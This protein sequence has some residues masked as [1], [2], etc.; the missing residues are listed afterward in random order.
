M[1]IK[2]QIG[3]ESDEIIWRNS[4][5]LFIDSNKTLHIIDLKLGGARGALRTL[6]VEK[7]PRL[8]LPIYGVP[9]NVS[10]GELEFSRFLEQLMK[11]KDKLRES[12]EIFPENKGML[13][14]LC[15]ATDFLV[16]R[17]DQVREVSLELIYPLAEPLNLR[18]IVQNRES[19]KLFLEEI[20][21]LYRSLRVKGSPYEEIDSDSAYRQKRV[22]E[23][24]QKALL[25]LR[26]KMQERQEQPIRLSTGDIAEARQDVEQRLKAFFSNP[27][28]CKGIALLHSAGSGKTSTTRNQILATPGKHIV[29]YMATRISLLDREYQ[30][31]NQIASQEERKITLVYKRE[32]TAQLK[33]A[34]HKGDSWE[35]KT[36]YAKGK[37][38]TAVEEIIRLLHQPSPPELLWA[39]VTLQAIVKT[40]RDHRTSKHLEDL[41]RPITK[42][43]HIHIILDEFLGHKNG[44]FAILELLQF[45]K[46]AR[47]HKRKINLYLFDA[48]AYSPNL[49]EKLI[50]E[51]KEFQVIPES[52]VLVPYDEE[53]KIAV[54]E[55]PLEIYAKHG[56]PS[57]QLIIQK[58]FVEVESE[59][60]IAEQV[61]SYI[62]A[63][64]PREESTAFLFL[65]NKDLIVETSNYLRGIGFSTLIATATSKKTQKEI[66][67]GGEDVILGTSSVSRGLD[68][69]RPHK[70]VNNIYIVVQN[71]GI[72]NNLVEILQ[73]VSRS[74]GDKTTESKPKTLHLLYLINRQYD[75]YRVETLTQML[76]HGDRNLVPLMYEKET[77]RGFVDLDEV[78][79]KILKQFLDRPSSQVLVLSR[80]NILVASRQM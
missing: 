74:R 35:L 63:T 31:L 49:L 16:E 58:R 47:D 69:S 4:D 53:R 44:L 79:T 67:E 60:K 11:I 39:F 27:A 76:E 19:L 66:N 78:I 55:I 8:P 36:N 9:V 28:P 32:N 2:Y 12:E 51:Y 14:M 43:Y 80:R 75:Q 62:K 64:L 6:L 59:G 40:S 37:L 68:F 22:R 61:S 3:E 71:W 29:I 25:D 15:Y 7:S 41:L 45:L 77:L 17:Q 46:R 34:R 30:Y 20:R 70:P 13:Q 5:L 1:P 18:F 72:E 52:L 23:Q 42:D 73:A 57:K 56:Y 24:T 10:T 38:A 50:Q 33:G 48:N 65:Q 21:E 54:E 26:K